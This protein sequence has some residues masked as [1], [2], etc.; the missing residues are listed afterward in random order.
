MFEFVS[1]S[2]RNIFF[3]NSK[4]ILSFEK[5]ILRDFMN[6]VIDDFLNRWHLKNFIKSDKNE[7]TSSDCLEHSH[8]MK[9]QKCHIVKQSFARIFDRYCSTRA[10]NLRNAMINCLSLT[11]QDDSWIDVVI[12]SIWIRINVEKMSSVVKFS[13]KY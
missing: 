9:I 8:K 13:M 6:I 11:N 3:W 4:F 7:I 12:D 5:W 1:H 2:I 10:W